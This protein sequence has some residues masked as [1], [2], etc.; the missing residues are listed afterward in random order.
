MLPTV[1]RNS[2]L[3]YIIV[4]EPPLQGEIVTMPV[5]GSPIN[6]ISEKFMMLVFHDSGWVGNNV[7][8]DHADI[9]DWWA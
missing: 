9:S 8:R 2:F 4:C 6:C 5:I 3:Y 1:D 7:C